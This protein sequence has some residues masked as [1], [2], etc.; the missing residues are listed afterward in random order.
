[1]RAE[2]GTYIVVI[3]NDR[4]AQLTCGRLGSIDFAVGRYFYIGSAFGPGGIR[5]RVGRHARTDKKTHWHIDYL[6]FVARV[7]GAWICYEPVRHEHDWAGQFAATNAFG[8]I[9]GFGCSDCNC[10]SHLF[11]ST[12]NPPSDLSLPDSVVYWSNDETLSSV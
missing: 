12:G 9:P 2:P 6:T 5:A 8:A 1:V 10:P 3:D 7:R 4:S 11:F